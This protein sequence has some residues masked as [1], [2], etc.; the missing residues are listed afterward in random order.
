MNFKV[1]VIL[2][3]INNA[4]KV[5][6]RRFRDFKKS[7]FYLPI[8][9][10]LHN[11]SWWKWDRLQYFPGFLISNKFRRQ[12]S[13]HLFQ[14]TFSTAHPRC[15]FRES[16]LRTPPLAHPEKFHFAPLLF[17]RYSKSKSIS[18]FLVLFCL[19]FL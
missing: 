11:P 17:C 16:V 15:I 7:P 2:N 14:R 3:T 19:F 5:P 12:V 4:K 10:D 6:F 1:H 13:H 9:P 8:R 18:R